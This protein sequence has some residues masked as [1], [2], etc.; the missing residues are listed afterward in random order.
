MPVPPERPPLSAG[1]LVWPE[2]PPPGQF[3]F[4]REMR[5]TRLQVDSLLAA[6]KIEEAEVY[7][8]Q[9]RLLFVE[10][11]HDLRKLNQAY[12][13]FYGSY[14]TNPSSGNPIGGQLQWL[15]AKSAS[16]RDYLRTA[17]SIS[18]HDDLLALLPGE[19]PG[20]E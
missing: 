4:V 9:R 18:Q 7:M 16:L 17:A 3:D 2:E 10:Q 5:N 13:A 12:F 6:G 15:R 11:G 14:A 1:E 8:E 19:G 20:A